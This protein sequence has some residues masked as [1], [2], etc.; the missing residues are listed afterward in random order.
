MGRGAHNFVATN[1]TMLLDDAYIH[2][3]IKLGGL[4]VG[5]WL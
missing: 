2:I 3:K 1:D 5:P 4:V